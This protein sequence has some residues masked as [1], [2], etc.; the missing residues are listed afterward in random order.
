M[1]IK[2]VLAETGPAGT[3]DRAMLIIITTIVRF[4]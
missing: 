2:T 3:R 4:I 1:E